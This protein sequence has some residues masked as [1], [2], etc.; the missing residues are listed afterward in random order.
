MLSAHGKKVGV[1]VATQ[2]GEFTFPIL[3]GGETGYQLLDMSSSS[4]GT[5]KNS[6][7]IEIS[8]E[9]FYRETEDWFL[10]HK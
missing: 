7:W 3:E 4:S 5:L 9:S 8:P 10:Y 6:G 2:S 1:V